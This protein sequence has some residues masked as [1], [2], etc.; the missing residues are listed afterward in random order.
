MAFITPRSSFFFR[1]SSLIVL[2]LS[3]IVPRSSFIAT[4][5]SLCRKESLS[6]I[7]YSRN[8]GN[9]PTFPPH[10]PR[11]NGFQTR[12]GVRCDNLER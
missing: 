4:C 10:F 8:P 6:V 3:F 12:A 2:L 5:S 1:R 11:E 9:V 7:L